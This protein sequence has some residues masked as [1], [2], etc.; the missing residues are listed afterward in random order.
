MIAYIIAEGYSD[1]TILKKILPQTLL[2]EVEIIAAGGKASAQSLARSLVVRRQVPVAIV[3]DADSIDTRIATQQTQE[4]TNMIE[5]VA[6]NTPVKV[7]LSVPAIESIFFDDLALLSK[8]I[9][10][11][12]P[13][14]T[15]NQAKTQPGLVLQNLL[16]QSNIKVNKKNGFDALLNRLTEQDIKILQLTPVMQELIEFLQ[17]VHQLVAV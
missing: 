16:S 11:E 17:S 5:S 3:A 14:D 15:I 13:E 2:K 7:I 10:Y 4:M 9:G 8:L 1:V 6:I 12:L